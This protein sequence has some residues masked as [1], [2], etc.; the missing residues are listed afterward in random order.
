MFQ[1]TKEETESLKA[2]VVSL[3]KETDD[4]SNLRS[5]TIEGNQWWQ[6]EFMVFNGKIEYRE[7]GGDQEPRVPGTAGQTVTLDFINGTGSIQ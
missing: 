4:D 1:V 6:T 5:Q 2:Q 3:E 7:K